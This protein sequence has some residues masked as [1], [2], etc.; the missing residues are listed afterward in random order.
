MKEEQQANHN[1]FGIIFLFSIL[2]A[3]G[4]L[5]VT[6]PSYVFGL[7]PNHKIIYSV[8]LCSAWF[9]SYKIGLGILSGKIKFDSNYQPTIH[10]DVSEQINMDICTG[11][12]PPGN[13][14]HNDSSNNPTIT[15]YDPFASINTSTT[16]ST[17]RD[18]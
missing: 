18:W 6:A 15:N 4:A 16:Y 14:W 7:M 3:A 10:N 2:F 12:T 9:C 8:L 13:R 1:I 11:I 5:L 17:H